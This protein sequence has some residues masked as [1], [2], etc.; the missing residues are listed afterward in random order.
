[1]LKRLFTNDKLM[2]SMILL[3]VVSIFIGGFYNGRSLF[4]YI[5]C[6]FTILFLV[7]AI[8]KIQDYTWAEYW[9]DGWNKF[10]FIVTIVALPSLLNLIDGISLPTNIA[11]SFRVLR[12]FKAFRLFEYI[13]NFNAV[14]RGIVLAI[15]ASFVVAIGFALLLL[16]VSILTSSIFGNIAPEYF[17]DPISSLYSTF[18][19]FSVE[20]W[21]EIPDLIAERTSIG[22]STFTKGYFAL[23]LFIGGILGMSLINAIFVDA[24]VSDNNDDV[25]ERLERIEKKLEQMSEKE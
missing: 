10:D 8:I 21:Y 15:K 24:A 11:L 3:N 17:G 7:E 4:L 6:I 19:L 22:F 2:L 1:M 5:D 12:V 9:K 18:R 20:G 25:K 23:L 16:I 13:P 14:I